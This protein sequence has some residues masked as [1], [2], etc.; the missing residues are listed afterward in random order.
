MPQGQVQQDLPQW[1]QVLSWLAER[2]PAQSVPAAVEPH[3]SESLRLP[4]GREPA[5][6]A[7]ARD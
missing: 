3:G 5:S 7:A 1:Q 4:V 2:R 6:G